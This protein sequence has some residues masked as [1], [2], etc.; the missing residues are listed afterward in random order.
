MWAI[1]HPTR[2]ASRVYDTLIEAR[3]RNLTLRER[4]EQL[5]RMGGALPADASLARKAGFSVMELR[6][7]GNYGPVQIKKAGFSQNEMI[8]GGINLNTLRAA[9][10]T[11]RDANEG[12]YL[13]SQ[14]REVGYT[15][16]EIG[17]ALRAH[18]MRGMTCGQARQMGWLCAEARSAGYLPEERKKAGYTINEFWDA[19]AFMA[20][21]KHAGFTWQEADTRYPAS[22]GNQGFNSSYLWDAANDYRP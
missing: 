1:L 21:V 18:K 8:Q 11:A 7:A 5:W 17:L 14:L 20:E 22:Y 9:G 16:E 2:P 3:T 13:L 12:G 15:V 10:Y 6:V 4:A 19:G